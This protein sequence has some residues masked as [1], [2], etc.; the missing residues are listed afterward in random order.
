M[1]NHGVY[2][3]NS[4]RIVIL[5]ILLLL[6]L[7]DTWQVRSTDALAVDTTKGG[8]GMNK[9]NASCEVFGAV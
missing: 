5:R 2:P 7:K 3:Y 9:K 8:E 4:I 1:D 6:F